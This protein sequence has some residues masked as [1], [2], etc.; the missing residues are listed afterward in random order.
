MGGLGKYSAREL[1]TL[2]FHRRPGGERKR[3][4][5]TSRPSSSTARYLPPA[6][7]KAVDSVSSEQ[8]RLSIVSQEKQFV[9]SS[10]C[11]DYFVLL[12]VSKY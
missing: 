5:G 10:T 1:R 3:G 4:R 7:A 2:I 11:Y 9:I 8:P 6:V 12:K